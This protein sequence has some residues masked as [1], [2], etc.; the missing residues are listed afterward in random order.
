MAYLPY[1]LLLPKWGTVCDTVSDITGIHC[2]HNWAPWVQSSLPFLQLLPHVTYL[3][4]PPP[5]LSTPTKTILH[6]TLV[7]SLNVNLILFNYLNSLV[8]SHCWQEK[9]PSIRNIRSSVIQ[10]LPDSPVSPPVTLPWINPHG[11]LYS[12]STLYFCICDFLLLI[13][14]KILS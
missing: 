4:L 9:S 7:L 3:L 2:P 10:V 6:T 8:A 12:L 14:Q 1:P 5:L 13:M 11:S